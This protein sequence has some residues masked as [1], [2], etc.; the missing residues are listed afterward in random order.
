MP[1]ENVQPRP[2]RTSS[3]S[4]AR[5]PCG[6]PRRARR[7]CARRG[8][9]WPSR[10]RRL[11]GQSARAVHLDRAV[12]HVVERLRRVELE[13]RHLDARLRALVDL[14]RRRRAS[15]AGRPG[16]RRPSRRSSSAPSACRPAGRR[17]PRAPASTSTSARTPAASGR[18]SASRGGCGPARAASVRS[19]RRRRARRACS[20]R[21]R[22]RRCS[23]PRSAWTSP[24]DVPITEIG[25]STS[26]PGVSTGTT[27][28]VPRRWGSR[29]RVGD[30][31]HDRERRP[32]GAGREPLVPV[33]HPLVAVEHRA[34]AQRGRIGA[35]HV[36]LGHREE[37]A[38]RPATS[39]SRKRSCWS[40]CRR[41]AGS[42]RCP[43]RAPG[44]RRRAAPRTS[45]RSPRSCTRSRG[46]RRPCRRPRAAGAAPTGLRA[47]SPCEHPHQLVAASSSRI[48][49][50]SFGIDVLLHERPV[51]RAGARGTRAGRGRRSRRVGSPHAP[52]LATRA[53][54]TRSSGV[55]LAQE[56]ERLG[57][58]SVWTVGGV[59]DGR[60]HP[61]GL[62][63]GDDGAHQGR[64]RDH[65]DRRRARPRR[66]RRPWPTLDLLSGGRVLLGLGTSGPQVVEG[67]HGQ[68]WGKPLARTREYVEIVRAIL[69]ARSRSSTTATHYDIP[70]SGPG[71][72]R[73]R[74][75]AED[76]RP[77]R[78]AP[79]CRSTWPRSGRGT[80]SS[81][82]RSP[83][84]GCRS[85][86]RP[87]ARGR[88]RPVLAE[89]FA[90]R[91]GRPDGLGPRA[92]RAGR[93]RRR[94]AGVPRLAEADARPL[95]RRHG[96]ARPELLQ[97]A[98]AALRLRGRGGGDPGPLPR[99]QE[100]RGRRAVPDA[101]VDEIA[102]VGDRERIADRL[103]AWR[104]TRRDDAR[105]AGA[106]AGGPAG[107]WRS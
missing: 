27:I 91:G 13:Q 107:C 94:R 80:S 15:A 42:R 30:R 36:G 58:D 99:R 86:S 18:A 11:V 3:G 7:R 38:A 1:Y 101:L 75:A 84:A 63:R 53:T 73:A 37:R 98:R 28:I 26:T 87:S 46:T 55:A 21:G 81:R 23:A 40:P 102:L 71:A 22:G 8:R 54:T 17:T 50:P 90:V 66:R 78:C 64:H 85:S 51:A 48:E 100:E 61:D 6:A 96:R 41:G 65:A 74:Q 76:D 62:D 45:G 34:R 59:G 35:G 70:Y 49:R 33:D 104:E 68:P 25:P 56:A 14:A 82:P 67:W 19:G 105:P 88:A 24:P 72:D 83:T 103:A 5:R 16:S 92:A 69:R 60:R 93:D 95:H 31:E 57:F 52:R 79:R 77:S 29:V 32:V 12:D 39:G 89:G 20:R 10:E 106:P 44:S 4:A 43:R 97:P 2:R 47:P 9:A